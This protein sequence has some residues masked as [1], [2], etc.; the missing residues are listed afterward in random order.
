MVGRTHQGQ[1]CG[2]ELPDYEREDIRFPGCCSGLRRLVKSSR[3]KD[4]IEGADQ[5]K[6]AKLFFTFPEKS[7]AHFWSTTSMKVKLA[8]DHLVR[9]TPLQRMSRS[10]LVHRSFHDFIST[11]LTRCMLRL[12]TLA[13]LTWSNSRLWYKGNVPWMQS[14]SR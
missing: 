9:T 10:R 13:R 12:L 3:I 5:C 6:Q 11:F 1:T 4:G 2:Y 7:Q 8:V 14:R